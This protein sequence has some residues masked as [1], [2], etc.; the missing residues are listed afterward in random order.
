MRGSYAGAARGSRDGPHIDTLYQVN[1]WQGSL[2]HPSRWS[3]ASSVSSV[4]VLVAAAAAPL[5]LEISTAL[6][7][8]ISWPAS[9]GI[10][11]KNQ[12]DAAEMIETTTKAGANM[13]A[14]SS[15]AWRQNIVDSTENAPTATPAEIASC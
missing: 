14:S 5:R 1:I 7:P 10:C 6:R 2:S 4:A 11:Q 15:V 9:S 8:E 3:R 12:A 13:L